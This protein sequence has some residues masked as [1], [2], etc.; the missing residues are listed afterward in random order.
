[1][2]SIAAPMVKRPP[3][4]TAGT[5][6]TPMARQPERGR[7]FSRPLV[8]L[9]AEADLPRQDERRDHRSHRKAYG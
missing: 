5:T 8:H 7:H 4:S 6:P 9:P 3:K 2:S 1:M